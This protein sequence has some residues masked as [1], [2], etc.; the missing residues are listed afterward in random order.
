MAIYLD[1]MIVFSKTREIHKPHLHQTLDTL[2][3]HQLVANPLK[4]EL[5]RTELLFLGN[6]LTSAGIKPNLVKV[7]FIK[8]ASTQGCR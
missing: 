8:N 4:C 7:E 6:I 2:W 5:F 3:K 1:N